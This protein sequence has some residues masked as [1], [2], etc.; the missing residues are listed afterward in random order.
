MNDPAADDAHAS[1]LIV[2]DDPSMRE[3]VA[4]TL[5][6]EDVEVTAAGTGQE[7][8]KAL[9][10]RAFAAAIVDLQMPH[11]DGLHLLRR[12]RQ[13][14][15]ATVRVVL[16]GNVNLQRALEAVNHGDAFRLLSKPC[17]VPVLQK[18]VRDAIEQHRMITSD[19]DLN[20]LRVRELSSQ[21]VESER[22]ALLGTMAGAIGHEL[23]NIQAALEMTINGITEAA[24]QGGAPDET[25]IICLTRIADHLR[26]HA[27]HLHALGSPNGPDPVQVDLGAETGATVEMLRQ[28]GMFS[29]VAVQVELAAERLP[30]AV[31]RVRLEQ[32]LL[33]LVKNAADA[34]EDEGPPGAIHIHA[35]PDRAAD[36]AVLTI[37]DNGLG[38]PQDV[39]PRIFE[40]YFTTKPPGKG[41]GLGLAV[42]KQIVEDSGGTISVESE[43]GVGT[44]FDLRFPLRADDRAPTA[45]PGQPS[46]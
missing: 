41:T 31:E 29:N 45:S 1:V 34:M 19:R 24:A 42:I 43:P 32:I 46:F 40:P 11:M 23:K 39:L 44:R 26:V 5:W 30:V 6:E 37:H 13:C 28:L 25:M 9:G 12:M 17:P 4:R 2:D 8:L 3:S 36:Q 16:S 27:E 20:A 21:L 35:Y 7:A 33:N 14:A 18:A 22:R 15:P 10:T 38:I